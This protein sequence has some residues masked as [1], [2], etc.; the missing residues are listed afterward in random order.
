MPHHAAGGYYQQKVPSFI[1]LP[2]LH[3]HTAALT[4]PTRCSLS[5]RALDRVSTSLR[6][7]STSRLSASRSRATCCLLAAREL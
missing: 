7:V 2:Y 4:F 5:I 6:P 3:T 1:C